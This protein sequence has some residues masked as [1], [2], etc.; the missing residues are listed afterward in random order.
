MSRTSRALMVIA[1]AGAIAPL[2]ACV[3]A[4]GMSRYR[5][6]GHCRAIERS[7]GLAASSC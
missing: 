6:D 2:P 3:F 4:P 7:A 1:G 5:E